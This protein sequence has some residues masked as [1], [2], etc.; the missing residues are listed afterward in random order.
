MTVSDARSE[1]SD[2]AEVRAIIGAIGRFKAPT[3]RIKADAP[4]SDVRPSST[5]SEV[6]PGRRG[7]V[8]EAASTS[9]TAIPPPHRQGL[10]T[11]LGQRP[12]LFRRAS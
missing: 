9:L 10:L 5:K 1:A 12:V 11:C 8:S 4:S 2:A 3:R 6:Q 7:G